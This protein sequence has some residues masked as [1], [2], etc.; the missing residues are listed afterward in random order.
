MTSILMVCLG[1]I[2][3]SPMA[4]AAML[5]AAEQSGL[6][7]IVDSAGTAAWHIGKAPDERG[8]KVVK[9]RANIDMSGY[10]ARQVCA[11]DFDKFD[12]I[13]AMDKQNLLDL[14]KIQ[15]ENSHASLGLLRDNEMSVADP[16]YGDVSDFE[17]VW[18]QVR[19]AAQHIVANLK[20]SSR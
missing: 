8:Q 18:S 2:C 4:E 17:T 9:L 1:N 6:D 3:R 11:A 13:Y 12:Y 16:Y 19:D 5:H 10:I 20:K 15:P 14:H 7:I